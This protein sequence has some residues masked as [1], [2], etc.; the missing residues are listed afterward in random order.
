M[1][2]YIF[3]EKHKLNGKQ[4]TFGYLKPKKIGEDWGGILW[5]IKIHSKELPQTLTDEENNKLCETL[6]EFET[7]MC[8]QVWYYYTEYDNCDYNGGF[9]ETIFIDKDEY[10]KD[11]KTF[12]DLIDNWLVGDAMECVSEC[13]GGELD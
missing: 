13:L 1:S 8:Y 5:K 4:I 3:T 9:L 2:N 6:N 7:D 11:K 12:I 10:I